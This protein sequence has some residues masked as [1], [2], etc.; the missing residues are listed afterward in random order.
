MRHRALRGFQDFDGWKNPGD[1]VEAEGLR[2]Q[3]LRS[4][5]LIGPVQEA[6]QAEPEKAVRSQP[7]AAVRPKAEA[8]VN[9]KRKAKE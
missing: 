2:E 8:A 4:A 3:R 5:R 6:T 7:P 9:Q 1:I